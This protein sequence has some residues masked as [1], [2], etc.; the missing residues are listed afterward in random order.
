MNAQPTRVLILGA[1]GM[2]GW[3]V[4]RLL[5]EDRAVAVTA[6]VRDQDTVPSGL[7]ELLGDRLIELDVTDD[8][9]RRGVIVDSAPDFVLNCVGVIKQDP[10]LKDHVPTVWINSLLPHLLANE[11]D[12]VDARLIQVSTDCVFSG[13]VGRYT[14]DDVPDPLDFYGRTK[15]VGELDERHLTLRTSII[16]PELRRRAS[17]VEWF[18]GQEDQTVRGFRRAIYSGVTT[19][20]FTRFLSRYVF[21][22]RSLTGLYQLASDAINKYDL[23]ELVAGAYEW[24][25]ELNPD[26]D[27][28]CDRS[29]VSERL[30]T[31]TGYQPPPWTEMIRDMAADHRSAKRLIGDYCA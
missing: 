19:V 14:E 11:C 17:L 25:G 15:L 8:R 20:E 1:A 29:L 24:S 16:G 10:R 27:F 4:S 12:K 6:A 9:A 5:L 21:P 30:R 7:A 2:L 13:R 3:T 22:D 23:L 31:A 18:L 26:D 28:V